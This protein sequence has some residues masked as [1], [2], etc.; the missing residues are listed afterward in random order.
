MSNQSQVRPL[1]IPSH[2]Q[3]CPSE[4]QAA[5]AEERGSW[6]LRFVLTCDVSAGQRLL[7]CIHGGRNMKNAWG[8]LQ[9]RDAKAEGYVSLY[10]EAGVSLP[11][12]GQSDDG[13]VFSF[14][15][16]QDGLKQ[17]AHVA[18]RLAGTVAPRYS[19]P[20]KFFL[21][22]TAQAGDE[23]KPPSLW[24]DTQGRI[25]GACMMDI[26]GGDPSG[27]RAVAPSSVAPGREFGVLVRPEDSIRNVACEEPGELIVRLDE[28]ELPARRVPIDGSKCCRLEG[29]VLPIEG[30]YRLEVEDATYGFVTVTNPI[31][32]TADASESVLW[33]SMHSHTEMSDGTGTLDRYLT[34][35]RDECAVDF[36]ATSD[37][38]RADETP[39][40]FWR[41]SQD[42][43]V[44]H[45]QP[46]EF[47]VF[48]GYE[49]AKWRKL[50]DGDRNVYYLHDRRPI[51]RSDDDAYPH[52]ADLFPALKDEDAIVIPHH[53]AHIGNHNDWKDHDP[54]KERLVEIYSLWGCSERSVEDGNIYPGAPVENPR[55]VPG[56][57]PLGYVQRAL[58]MGWRVGF[59]ANADDHAGH[60]SDRIL[61]ARNQTGGLTGV[62]ADE[63]TRE[64]I[65]EA[66][67]TRRCYATTGDRIIVDFRLDGHAMGSEL[68]LSEHPELASS[69][70]ISIAVNGTAKIK[71]I[72][73]VRNNVD[74]HTITPAG[75]DFE[76]E[77]VD[78]DALADVDLPPAQWSAVPFTFYY[79]RITQED[80]QIAWASPVW[81]ST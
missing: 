8:G 18:A 47:T 1:R 43:V 81:I 24:G 26:T 36:G 29:I 70:R 6:T 30:V 7:L 60:S 78:S 56:V 21:L 23:I 41:M 37:H 72:E 3:I 64:A 32:C 31:V 77:W 5:K 35:M 73:I 79:V 20:G 80:R 39:E 71:T 54:E 49:W 4:P 62:Y 45:N 46:G 12:D 65:F 51:F 33:G 68:R 58:A 61:R 66:L 14:V 10:T 34:E 48:L 19:Q 11:C 27:F 59:S 52:P 55:G 75:P 17:G 44:R 74:I 40:E 38:D 16:P 42:A 67:R 13:G 53:P 76:C 63:N 25:A 9:S 15:V 2:V 22:M 69:R 28:V 57:N 50:G